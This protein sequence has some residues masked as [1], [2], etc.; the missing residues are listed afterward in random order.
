MGQTGTVRAG[1]CLLVCTASAQAVP[2]TTTQAA[3]GDL[4]ELVLAYFQQDDSTERQ[5]TLVRIE[6]LDGATVQKVAE[7]VRK[8][9]LWESRP[10]RRDDFVFTTASGERRAVQVQLPNGYDPAGRYPLAL[11]L[12]GSGGGGDDAVLDNIV[13]MIGPQADGFIVAVPQECRGCVFH[14]RPGETFE[15]LDLLKELRRRYH[16]DTDRVYVLGEG[17][18]GTAALDLAISCTHWLA[19][20]VSMNGSPDVPYPQ[21]ALELLLPNLANTPT[22]VVW[23][24]QDE[25]A[26]TSKPG[27]TSAPLDPNDIVRQVAQQ[28][29]LPIHTVKLRPGVREPSPAVFERLADVLNSRRNVDAHQVS[30]WFRYPAH[31]RS[32]WLRQVAFESFV[33]DAPQITI[34][35]GAGTD[36]H[37]YVTKI[38]KSKMAFLAGRIEGQNIEVLTTNTTEVEVRLHA[39]LLDLNQPIQIDWNGQR[40]FTIR[41][42]PRVATLLETAHED[43][44]FQHL[45]TVRVRLNPTDPPRQR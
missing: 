45:T 6:E 11:G 21:Q 42:A 17:K 30:H 39:G 28:Y 38:L 31:G 22:L 8:A 32:G 16:V 43:W 12:A 14:S 35:P 34:L 40:R 13:A 7:A 9:P 1:L 33:W 5:K 4:D 36:F 29:G 25:A 26:A 15:P 27:P 20:A 2:P 24:G 37:A 23:V 18:G 19:G 10:T 44:E 41:V 3:P